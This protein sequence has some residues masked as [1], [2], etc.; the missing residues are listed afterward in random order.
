MQNS[1]ATRKV[2]IPCCL[3][4][5]RM[6]AADLLEL[7]CRQFEGFKLEWMSPSEL[8]NVQQ[9]LDLARG[10]VAGRIALQNITNSSRSQHPQLRTILRVADRQG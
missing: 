6:G 8:R 2:T 10:C 3:G 1:K 4:S 7:V 5:M 9:P